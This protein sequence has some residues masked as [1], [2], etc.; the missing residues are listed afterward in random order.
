MVDYPG[1]G[2][3]GDPLTRDPEMVRDDV[4]LATLTAAT[5]ALRYGVVLAESGKVDDLATDDLRAKMLKA[6]LDDAVMPDGKRGN[7]VTTDGTHPCREI[8][9]GLMAVL[10]DGR[11][12]WACQRCGTSLGSVDENFKDASARLDTD[13]HVLDP[14]MYPDVADF[15][16]VPM[17]LRQYLCPSCGLMLS[18]QLSRPDDPPTWEVK[19]DPT[20]A[21]EYLTTGHEVVS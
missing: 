5:A 2:G 20:S 18:V 7:V 3:F 17:V 14:K 16:D 9:D 13:P 10:D 11:A 19:L 12:V 21:L 8:G 1:G 6:R 15:C 4:A